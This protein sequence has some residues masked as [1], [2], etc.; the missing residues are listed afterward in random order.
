LSEIGYQSRVDNSKLRIVFVFVV[1][2]AGPNGPTKIKA[3]PSFVYILV[4]SVHLSVPKALISHFPTKLDPSFVETN[5]KNKK[6]DSVMT[7]STSPTP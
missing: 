7:R 3:K 5:R 2:K 4:E 6:I 1:Y